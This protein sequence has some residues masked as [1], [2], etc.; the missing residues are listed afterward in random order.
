[1]PP[2]FRDTPSGHGRFVCL[3]V[4]DPRLRPEHYA[5]VRQTLDRLLSNRLPSV[6]IAHSTR[7]DNGADEL[8]RRY[9]EETCRC[10]H[11][12][13]GSGPCLY[14]RMLDH[15]VADAVVVFHADGKETAEVIRR[16]RAK[17]IPL[18]VVDVRQFVAPAS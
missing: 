10:S 6:R 15:R 8:A 14:E 11:W 5:I 9:A 12:H 2:S 13:E 16:T 1:M 3:I 4:G 7:N 18:R 17:R